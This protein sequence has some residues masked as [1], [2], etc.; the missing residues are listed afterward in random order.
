MTIDYEYKSKILQTSLTKEINKI[1]RRRYLK[2]SQGIIEDIDF[3][4]DFEELML[5]QEKG[6]SM[7][8]IKEARKINNATYHRTKRLQTRILKYLLMGRC[9]FATLSFRDDVLSETSKETRR[10]YV[11]RFLKS[12][13]QYYVANIDYGKTTEREHYHAVIVIDKISRGSWSYGFD[14]YEKVR[15]DNLTDLRLSKYISKL[16]NHAIKETT[17]RNCYIYSRNRESEI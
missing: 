15:C 11:A 12:I 4:I 2:E 7:E 5:I 9:V 6:Y 17:K 1:D 14:K 13:S 3:D 10:R 8:D 16:T